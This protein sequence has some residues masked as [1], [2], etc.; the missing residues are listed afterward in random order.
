M[1]IPL[2]S[3]LI[4]RRGEEALNYNSHMNFFSYYI[5]NLLLIYNNYNREYLVKL[6]IRGLFAGF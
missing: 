5:V 6:Y 1:R 4:S 2:L 3:L